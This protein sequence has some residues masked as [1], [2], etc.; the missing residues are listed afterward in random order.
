M[1]ER[2][3]TREFMCDI[4]DE[5]NDDV[6]VIKNEMYSSGRWTIYYDLVFSYE[7]RTYYTTYGRGATEMQDENPWKYEKEVRCTEVEPFEIVDIEWR[8]VKDVEV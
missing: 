3:F 2:T 6:E 8:P 1:P 5:Y 7:G 4:L